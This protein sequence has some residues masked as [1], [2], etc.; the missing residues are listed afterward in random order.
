[1][2]YKYVRYSRF[3]WIIA[4]F[5]FLSSITYYLKL[6]DVLIK[7]TSSYLEKSSTSV[8]VDSNRNITVW[9]SDFHISPV[10][11]IK[12]LLNEFGVTFIDK[13][14][15]GETSIYFFRIYR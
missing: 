15:S 13:S 11:D 3:S 12:Y 4:F 2:Y 5:L 14:L 7:D 1:M 6:N 9:S 10:A 8:S